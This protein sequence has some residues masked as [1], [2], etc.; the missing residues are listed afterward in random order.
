MILKREGHERTEVD[1]TAPEAVAMPLVSVA[2]EQAVM[3]LPVCPDGSPQC[4]VPPEEEVPGASPLDTGLRRMDEAILGPSPESQA[5]QG[6]T[7]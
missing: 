6:G 7:P 4:E 1:L 2:D 3:P 5:G